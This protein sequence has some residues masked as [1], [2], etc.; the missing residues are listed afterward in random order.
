M[1]SYTIGVFK[2]SAPFWKTTG[3]IP[4]TSVP[5]SNTSCCFYVSDAYFFHLPGI[6][7]AKHFI[8]PSEVSASP[9]TPCS[10]AFRLK[11]SIVHF[12]QP[13]R[14]WTGSLRTC[15][16]F[17]KNIWGIFREGHISYC[18]I[19]MY[20]GKHIKGFE[21]LSQRQAKES[22]CLKSSYKNLRILL[23]FPWILLQD[24]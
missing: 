9:Q 22:E 17:W 5:F 11:D 1:L 7:M 21:K 20:T 23:K 19:D 3:R 14:R 8:F 4:K 2:T 6:Y 13:E 15:W 18:K 10:S 24:S 12:F 16:N